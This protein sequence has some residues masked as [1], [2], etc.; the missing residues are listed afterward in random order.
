[1]CAEFSVIDASQN[2]RFVSP[3]AHS[4]LLSCPRDVPLPKHWGKWLLGGQTLFARA[5]TEDYKRLFSPPP[6]SPSLLHTTPIH[7]F[8]PLPSVFV[9]SVTTHLSSVRC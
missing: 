7:Q 6:F 5:R 1:M 9:L 2:E 4:L 8:C 3:P